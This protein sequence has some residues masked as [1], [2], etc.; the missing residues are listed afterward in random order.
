[1]AEKEKTRAPWTWSSLAAPTDAATNTEVLIL[2]YLANPQSG[3]HSREELRALAGA[4]SVEDI[5]QMLYGRQKR[6]AKTYVPIIA[7]ALGTTVEELALCAKRWAE[8]GESPPEFH[9]AIPLKGSDQSRN[10]V[11][12][13]SWL[14]SKGITPSKAFALKVPDQFLAEFEIFE[15]DLL[16]IDATDTT[17][18]PG[19]F[20]AV[21]YA[22]MIRIYRA[23]VNHQDNYLCVDRPG[24]IIPH[25]L[26]ADAKVLGRAIWRGTSLR[27]KG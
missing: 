13:R 4:K 24:T 25:L 9:D 17:F 3:G 5:A 2:R 26:F 8:N 20:Y 19:D 1:M 6:M 15:G 7:E 14:K 18:W 21:E 10:Y 22:G 11:F 23:F 16:L 12:R 27:G